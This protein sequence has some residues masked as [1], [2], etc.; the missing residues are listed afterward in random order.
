MEM[1]ATLTS[2]ELP[3]EQ[4]MRAGLQAIRMNE[5][6]DISYQANVDA[7]IRWF[8]VYRHLAVS[9]VLMTESDASA[10]LFKILPSMIDMSPMNRPT[11]SAIE[12]A[13]RSIGC[14][15]CYEEHEPFEAATPWAN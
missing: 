9:T 3:I 8:Q 11:A 5:A 2:K 6:G 12:D 13:V 15:H 10:E 14:G 7:V 4:S 1:L